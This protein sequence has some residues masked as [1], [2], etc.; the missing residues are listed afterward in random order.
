[1]K[2]TT[3]MA[4]TLLLTLGGCALVLDDYDQY[5]L[6]REPVEVLD[7]PSA[8]YTG[9]AGKENVGVCKAGTRECPVGDVESACVGEILPSLEVCVTMG[10]NL[11]EDCDGASCLH[12]VLWSDRIGD[13]AGSETLSGLVLSP[14]GGMVL[15]GTYIGTLAL[16]TMVFGS[17]GGEVVDFV[18]KYG[19][20]KTPQWVKRAMYNSFTPAT[21][22]DVAVNEA[23]TTFITGQFVFAGNPYGYMGAVDTSGNMNMDFQFGG[24]TG[25]GAGHAVAVDS[26]GLLHF[27]GTT[28]GVL[29]PPCSGSIHDAGGTRDLVYAQSSAVALGSCKAGVPFPGGPH[30]PT[31]IA[32]G[33]MGTVVI[34][35][36][37]GG[38]LSS[39]PMA[40]A[41]PNGFILQL[42]ATTGIPL[43]EAH[44]APAGPQSKVDIDAVATNSA[45]HIFVVGTI[46][47][48]VSTDDRVLAAAADG[49]AF[50]AAYD[51][52][53]G[54]NPLWVRIFGGV[55][56]QRGTGVVVHAG[57]LLV[58]GSSNGVLD[59]GTSEVAKLPSDSFGPFWIE[60]AMD[61]GDVPWVH[62]L[63]S[64]S[65][66]V[67]TADILR[68]S[69]SPVHSSKVALGG[70]SSRTIRLGKDFPGATQDIF[71]GMIG[72]TP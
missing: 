40:N 67:G 65:M 22:T 1:M 43:W 29:V 26:S 30:N 21:V 56:E 36:T 37:Y 20:D 53:V 17:S 6:E 34:V 42:A 44:I 48:D 62:P 8:C 7:C 4:L 28:Q 35:G 32:V 23:N 55:G 46:I 2:S 27:V 19:P 9:L 33:P 59:F 25:Q 58:S 64:S 13:M 51:P 10:E 71:F 68:I 41:L 12:E 31:D 72:Q 38:T 16:D 49:D 50:V 54:K 45:G 47:N 63:A 69:T 61:T 14:D 52:A 57:K 3:V 5:S 39:L 24:L 18:A 60:L 11:D 15:T 66:Q 70:T